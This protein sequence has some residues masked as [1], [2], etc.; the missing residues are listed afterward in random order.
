[1]T[2]LTVGFLK[3]YILHLQTIGNK[4]TK[5]KMRP[6]SNVT[7]STYLKIMGS[8]AKSA[9]QE[10]LLD[11]AANPFTN[12]EEL[13]KGKKG[14]RKKQPL[15]MEAL[16]K[17]AEADFSGIKKGKNLTLSRDIYLAQYY[18][19]GSRGGDVLE[20]KVADVQDRLRYT[21]RKNR[22]GKSIVLTPELM[23]ILDRYMPRKGE[24][25]TFVF[26]VLE[27][28]Y[29]SFNKFTQ[30]SIRDNRKATVN[31]NLKRIAKLLGLE[32]FTMHTARHTFANEALKHTDLRTI[33][34]ML[35]HSSL[36]TT[37]VYVKDLLEGEDDLAT[38]AIYSRVK[39]E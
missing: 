23:A 17:L 32:P 15:S 30:K 5:Q 6:C 35:N 34:A 22:K 28:D 1:M 25:R 39:L 2:Q 26:P 16:G 3:D 14:F 18:M 20:L 37:E 31:R 24:S 21:M 29:L 38:A 19:H 27:E 13:I 8:V 4:G 36:A 7:I 9:M 10:G 33:K 11:Y 12:A